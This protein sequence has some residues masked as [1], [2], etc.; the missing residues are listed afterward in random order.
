MF[1]KNN[2]RLALNA[3]RRDIL[4]ALSTLKKDLGRYDRLFVYYSGHSYID[5]ITGSGFWQGVD[6]DEFDDFTWVSIDSVTRNLAGMQAKLV[7]VAA[8]SAFPVAVE[9]GT[10]YAQTSD[11]GTPYSANHRYFEKIDS[12]ASRKLIVSGVLV[13]EANTESGTNSVFPQQLVRVLE[14]NRD[15]YITSNQLFDRLSRNVSGMSDQNPE[16]GTVAN[17][18]DEGSG[19]LTFILRAKPLASGE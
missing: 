9:R 6:A 14:K 5:D 2:V 16:W 19:E 8:D 3:T 18:G 17:A 13:P 1:E 7:M 15:C 12:W 10:A 4:S 11:G